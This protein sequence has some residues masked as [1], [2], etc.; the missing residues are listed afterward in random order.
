MLQTRDLRQRIGTDP[1][2]D[3]LPAMVAW[4]ELFNIFKGFVVVVDALEGNKSV[5]E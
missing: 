4:Q 2:I 1:Q 3:Y 5:F